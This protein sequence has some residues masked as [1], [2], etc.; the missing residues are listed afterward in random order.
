MHC[1]YSAVQYK[2]TILP[3]ATGAVAI[4]LPCIFFITTA[5]IVFTLP[6]NITHFYYDRCCWSW[7][8]P[9][10]SWRIL[11]WHSW[12]W[13]TP[14]VSALPATT[15][16]PMKPSQPPPQGSSCAPWVHYCPEGSPAP[17]PCGVGNYQ[18]DVGRDECI[19][20]QAGFYCQ[21]SLFPDPTPCPPYHYCPA[22]KFLTLIFYDSNYLHCIDL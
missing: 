12:T 20:C 5:I 22:G 3:I 8:L 14:P 19:Q 9:A 2:V 6:C 15:A 7:R 4:T 10:M 11:L 18:P 16:H 13:Q 1:Y 17:V 21:S